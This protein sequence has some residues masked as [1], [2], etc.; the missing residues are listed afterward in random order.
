MQ[1]LKVLPNKNSTFQS[2]SAPQLVQGDEPLVR[3]VPAGH[4]LQAAQGALQDLC[5]AQPLQATVLDVDAPDELHLLQVLQ[6]I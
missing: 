2:K 6:A 3:D 4:H 5:G 1:I